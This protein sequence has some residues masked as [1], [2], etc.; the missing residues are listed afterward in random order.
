VN[1]MSTGNKIALHAAAFTIIGS[2][3]GWSLAIS[4]ES[5]SMALGLDRIAAATEHNSRDI[6]EIRDAMARIAEANAKVEVLATIIQEHERRLGVV[7]AKC[8]D[9]D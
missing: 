2:I 7:E 3:I 5:R 9:K 4:S 8:E 1:N 6:G